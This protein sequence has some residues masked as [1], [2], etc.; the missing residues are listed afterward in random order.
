MIFGHN[1]SCPITRDCAFVYTN[2][3]FSF[4][5]LCFN[6][7]STMVKL[8]QLWSNCEGVC[9]KFLSGKL[10]ELLR[11]CQSLFLGLFRQKKLMKKTIKPIPE[12]ASKR[13]A[14]YPNIA[15]SNKGLNRTRMN[16][17]VARLIKLGL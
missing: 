7:A 12:G 4:L 14:V 15:C 13:N 16:E 2:L 10:L 17:K 5:K 1:C 11:S 3:F 8:L 6:D 9:L